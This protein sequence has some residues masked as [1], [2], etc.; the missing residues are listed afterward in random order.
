M[1]VSDKVRG[2]CLVGSGPVGSSRARVVEFSY[3]AT[4]EAQASLA[5]YAW[6]VVG[7]FSR[8][9]QVAPTAQERA[10]PRW[11]ASRRL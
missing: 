6:S 8:I 11:D 3:N 9:C 7:S 5:S 2:L 10:I 4:H 1:R